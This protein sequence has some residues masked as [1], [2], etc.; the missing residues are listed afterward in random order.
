MLEISATE[1]F[2]N[3]Y[4]ALPLFVRRKADKKTEIF[5]QNPFHPSLRTKKLEPHHEEIWSFWVDKN[6]RI[7]FRFLD[8]R[9]VH[10][11]FIGDRKNI[12][13]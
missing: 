10:L 1:T 8:A 11:L 7:K 2:K 4:R 13:R 6:Y 9:N 12:Y 3:L 5:R